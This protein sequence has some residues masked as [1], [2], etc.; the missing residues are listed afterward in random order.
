MYMYWL[1]LLSLH[2]WASSV[3]VIGQTRVIEE[4]GKDD[5]NMVGMGT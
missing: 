3:E 1:S 5:K 2:R 4:I